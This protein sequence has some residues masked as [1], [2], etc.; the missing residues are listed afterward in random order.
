MVKSVRSA[1]F[2]MFQR[3]ERPTSAGAIDIYATHSLV[4]LPDGKLMYARNASLAAAKDVLAAQ[5]A[6]ERRMR[7][8]REARV[9]GEATRIANSVAEPAR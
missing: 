8:A 1:W 4:V 7:E 3:A 9:F 6:A 2:G 5:R